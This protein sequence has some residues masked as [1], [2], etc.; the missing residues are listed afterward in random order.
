MGRVNRRGGRKR[1]AEEEDGRVGRGKQKWRKKKKETKKKGSASLGPKRYVL[2]LDS[3]VLA[4]L[5]VVR[6]FRSSFF[7]FQYTPER[8]RETLT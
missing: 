8:E 2:H 5:V 3:T 4:S 7:S 1:E 6:L